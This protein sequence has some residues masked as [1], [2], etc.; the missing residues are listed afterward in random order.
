MAGWSRLSNIV[1]SAAPLLGTVLGGPAGGSVAA[2]VS[3]VLGT[4]PDD[5]DEAIAILEQNP[6]KL[7]DLKALEVNQKTKF[8]EL[9]LEQSKLEMADRQDARAMYTAAGQ[10]W[11]AIGLTWLTTLGFFGVIASLIAGY[12]PEAGTTRD[13]MLVLV[14]ILGAAW[15]DIIG[16]FFG[17]S[18]GSKKKSEQLDRIGK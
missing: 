13:I 18:A 4:D 1:K 2:L 15:K 8:E 12:G 14:G 5:E 17:S 11:N 10:D 16:F 9:A 6:E 3:S 7:Y